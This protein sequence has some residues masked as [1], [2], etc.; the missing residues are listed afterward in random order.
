MRCLQVTL[1]SYYSEDQYGSNHGWQTLEEAG[2]RAQDTPGLCG[3]QA[4]NL[5]MTTIYTQEAH[6]KAES[7]EQSVASNQQLIEGT[8]TQAHRSSVLTDKKGA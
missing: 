7:V 4:C 8:S 3:L 1:S 2:V 6:S 5:N